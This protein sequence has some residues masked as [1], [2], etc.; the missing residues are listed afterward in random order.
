MPVG[1]GTEG[2]KPPPS[3]PRR[4]SPVPP[5]SRASLQPIDFQ[6]VRAG[7]RRPTQGGS[8]GQAIAQGAVSAS[9]TGGGCQQT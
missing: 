1:V 4:A 8:P 7:K 9:R 3:I 2:G 6:P 5:E